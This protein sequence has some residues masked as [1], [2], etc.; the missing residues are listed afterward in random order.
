MKMNPRY[1]IGTACSAFLLFCV[2]TLFFPLPWVNSASP[3]D[4]DSNAHL[5]R[6]KIYLAAGDYRRAV[7]ACQQHLNETPSAEG[8]VYLAY[9]YEAIEGYLVALSKRDDWVQ[10]GHLSL[11]LTE[12]DT[13]DLIDPA[14][15]LPRMA[16]ELI[17]DGVRQKF[18]ITAAMANRIDKERTDQLWIQQKAWRDAQPDRWWT[19]FPETWPL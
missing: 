3:G 9:V 12:R 19:A 1:P 4:S 13:F 18:D 15:V 7:E 6:A 14:N 16:R 10:V 8:Y 2:V 5:H 17:R 11:N